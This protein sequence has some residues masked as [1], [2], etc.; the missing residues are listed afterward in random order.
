M[1]DF[2]FPALEAF[3]AGDITQSDVCYTL[4]AHLLSAVPGDHVTGLDA[5]VLGYVQTVV[6]SL[7]DGNRAVNEAAR[8]P[9]VLREKLQAGFVLDSNGSIQASLFTENR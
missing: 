4:T 9:I 7:A 8:V 2:I 6:A 5:A 1:A 3:A